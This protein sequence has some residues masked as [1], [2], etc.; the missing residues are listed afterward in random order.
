MGASPIFGE[1]SGGGEE[2]KNH[3]FGQEPWCLVFLDTAGLFLFAYILIGL[4]SLLAVA[5]GADIPFMPFWHEPW[6]WLL[7]FAMLIP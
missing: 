3:L 2:M 7:R 4:V 5:N 1:L 6:R